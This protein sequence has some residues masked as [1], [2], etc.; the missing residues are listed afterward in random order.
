MSREANKARRKGVMIIAE[1]GVNHNGDLQTALKMIGEAAKAGVDYVKFQTF[2]AEKLVAANAERAEYQKANCGG[3]ETQFEM[4]KRLELKEEDFAILAEE[5]RRQGVGFLS[6]PFDE[7]SIDQLAHLGQDYWKIPSGEITN[8]PYLRKIG[9]QD[10]RVILSTGMS[11]LADVEAAVEV[12]EEAGTPRKDIILLHCNTQYPTPMKDVNLLAMKSLEQIG[13]GAVGFSDHTEGIEA[14]IAAAALGAKV[15]EKH[16]T[17]DKRMDGP[18]HKASLDCVELAAMAKAVR[19]IEL[20]LGEGVKCVSD[21]ERGNAGVAR[22]SIV[23]SRRIKAGEVMD[24][25]NLTTKRPGTGISP[26][27]WD[28]ICGSVAD[29]DYEKDEMIKK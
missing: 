26:M 6:S 12:L 7:D 21:S 23:A 29:R 8:K 28:E 20:A 25:K 5:C 3:E 4:L 16:F 22:K 19:N 27:L 24:E 10:G 13:A 11:T 18:D 17:L 15:I 2:K 14:D 1:A 9:E